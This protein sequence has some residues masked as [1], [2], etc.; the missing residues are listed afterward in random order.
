MCFI[1]LIINALLT[2]YKCVNKALTGKLTLFWRKLEANYPA[3]PPPLRVIISNLWRKQDRAS[4]ER[5][6]HYTHEGLRTGVLSRG[7]VKQCLLRIVD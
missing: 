5:F 6:G 3:Q 2:L 1:F 4:G 7:Q